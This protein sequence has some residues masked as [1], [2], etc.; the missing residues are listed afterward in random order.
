MSGFSIMANLLV[1]LLT[2]VAYISFIC[3]VAA[4]MPNI[5]ASMV[6]AFILVKRTEFI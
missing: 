5:K 2:R 6:K 1:F 3:V 4:A